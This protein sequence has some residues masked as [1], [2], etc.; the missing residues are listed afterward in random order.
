MATFAELL[1]DIYTITNRPDLVAETKLALKAATL[2]A[3]QSDFYPK[4]LYETGIQ[5][6]TPAY[7]QSLEYRSLIPR[8]RA[9]KFLRK[10]DSTGRIAGDF[11][12]LLTP[13]QTVDK[14]N[15]NRE[16][17]C[18]LAGQMLEIRSSTQDHYMLVGCYLQPDVTEAFYTSWIAQDHPYLLVYE[19]ARTLF[20]TIGFDEQSAQ[21]D[22]LVQEQFVIL[23]QEVTA[24]GE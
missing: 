16:D 13:E 2:K 20:K 22:R 6:A 10:L 12:P 9:F 4:D 3:H 5:W 19:A 7:I 23:K 15:V 21:M 24:Y 8:W 17:I 1:A 14:Y 18:Y 11:L